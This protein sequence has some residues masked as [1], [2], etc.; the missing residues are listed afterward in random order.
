[1]LNR[2][3]TCLLLLATLATNAQTVI[4]SDM[5]NRARPPFAGEYVPVYDNSQ[6]FFLPSSGS[7][8]PAQVDHLNV[9][10][11]S[12]RFSGYYTRGRI[13]TILTGKAGLVNL[14]NEIA[15]NQNRATLINGQVS[16]IR[17]SLDD[18]R[19]LLNLIRS[20][21]LT[22]GTMA[23]LLAMTGTDTQV[24]SVT[25]P[26]RAGTFYLDLND[27]TTP[28][29]GGTVIITPDGKRWKR[30][31]SGPVDFRWWLPG[32]MGNT[33][34]TS[35][36][37]AAANAAAGG[38][39]LLFPG[40]FGISNRITFSPGTTVEGK[41]A[42]I[43]ALNDMPVAPVSGNDVRPLFLAN[44]DTHFIKVN[45]DGNN[46]TCD[47]VVGVFINGF[48]VERC[49]AFHYGFKFGFAD[50]ASSNVVY[51]K[52]FV[53]ETTGFGLHSYKSNG[54]L[55]DHCRA[56]IAFSGYYT[57]WAKNVEVLG[58]NYDE[59]EDVS[60]DFE[61]GLNCTAT[62]INCTGF[63]IGGATI[64]SG[65]AE[66]NYV[67]GNLIFDNPNL[68][69]TRTYRAYRINNGVGSI[70]TLTSFDAAACH[71]YSYAPKQY[72]CGFKNGTILIDSLAGMAFR[73]PQL[74][75]KTGANAFFSN[76]AVSSQDRF[77]E[78]FDFENL[79]INKCTFRGLPG[80][81]S[82]ENF[83]R[84]Q[85][86][87]RLLANTFSYDRPKVDKAAVKVNTQTNYANAPTLVEGNIFINTGNWALLVDA[88]NN[89]NWWAQVN[90]NN[91]GD[92]YTTFGGFVNTFNGR[93]RFRNQR[94]NLLLPSGTTSLD[95]TIPA[96][97]G[98]GY[99]SRAVGQLSYG[100]ASYNGSLYNLSFVSGSGGNMTTVR[101]TGGVTATL[102]NGNSLTLTNGI[103]GTVNG[104]LS[105]TLDSY[106]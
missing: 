88:F 53:Y 106:Q 93:T 8:I 35:K 90:D 12:A 94:L 77:F 23:G 69:S 104:Y 72:N 20:A 30:L 33:D 22:Q 70:I 57:G 64:Y 21:K 25:D 86:A 28:A 45:L 58:G 67:P 49:T 87:G 76:F 29:N 47:G 32:V 91:L 82:K 60:V 38:T 81:E 66:D 74:N 5:T 85:S 27:S 40:T 34:E 92:E 59:I 52:C 1:M 63:G 15:L 19:V 51:R 100:R 105:L 44:N 6:L 75:T 42:T 39:L 73:T 79:T 11:L 37:Q 101:E 83:F 54:V 65:N 17:D 10:G 24:Y 55:V 84:E 43:R 89:P 80:S 103:G 68:H 102:A 50:L 99:A 9:V 7:A 13:D 46:K 31:F 62:D 16:S 14:N 36:L 95:G 2:F 3:L 78:C 56:L 26:N 18:H 71:I 98:N 97:G 96:I 4:R 48:T 41:S 61:G